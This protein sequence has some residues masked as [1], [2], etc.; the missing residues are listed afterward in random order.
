MFPNQNLRSPTLAEAANGD[1]EID[2]TMLRAV[3]DLAQRDPSAVTLLIGA[4]PPPATG[5]TARTVLAA[6][7]AFLAEQAGVGTPAWAR[8]TPADGAVASRRDPPDDPPDHHR[9]PP[10]PRQVQRLDPSVSTATDTNMTG[11][12]RPLGWNEIESYLVEVG[13]ELERNLLTCSIIVV[14]GAYVAYRGVRASTTDVDTI[15]ELGVDLRAAVAAVA[16][17]HGT[18]TKNPTPTSPTGSRPSCLTPE[19]RWADAAAWPI[20]AAL[21]NAT[22]SGASNSSLEHVYPH[23]M[24]ATPG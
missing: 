23:S 17:R 3:T 9:I 6:V 13:A 24:T 8:H 20:R 19:R 10:S 2:W 18:H 15:Y 14:G 4:E 7:A 1:D 21:A 12:G 16:R 5:T 22:R 11:G